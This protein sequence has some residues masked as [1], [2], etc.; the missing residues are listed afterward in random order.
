MNTLL[1]IIALGI[2]L[3]VCLVVWA[4][5]IPILIFVYCAWR[6]GR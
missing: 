2:E 1:V 4:V 5:T 3:P 6:D